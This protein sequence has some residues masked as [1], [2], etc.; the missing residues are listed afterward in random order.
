MQFISYNAEL[1]IA[2]LLFQRLFNN[3]KIERTDKNGQTSWLRIPCVFGQRSRILKSFENRDRQSMYKLPLIVINRT[4]YSRQGDRLNN[5]HNEVKYEITSKNRNLQYLTPVPIDISYDVSVIAKYQADIDKIAS[6]FMVFFN[7][8]V[9]VS[10]EHPKFEGV[11]LHNEIIMSDSVSEEHPDEFD[12]SQDDIV[13]STFQFTFKTYLF[14]GTKQAKKKQTELSTVLSTVLSTYVY[15]FKSDDEIRQYIS[16]YPH[17]ML[18]T[19]MSSET[20]ALVDIEVSSGTDT[21][22]DGIPLIKNIDVGFYAVPRKEDI[23]AYIMSVDNELIAKHE[24][25]T[26]AAYISSDGYLSNYAVRE[27][28]TE[29]GLSTVSVLTSLTPVGDYYEPVDNWCTLAPYVDRLRWKIDEMSTRP[30]PDNVGQY[31]GCS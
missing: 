17:N 20:T 24:H 18:S 6:N 29:E 13:T 12:G 1:G 4:G 22:D 27:V 23:D 15:E 14:G 10:Q 31:S 25:Y 16:A 30:F 7:S 21:Y 28:K 26:S 19:V 2:N 5:L 8:N 9:W 3:I 11:K